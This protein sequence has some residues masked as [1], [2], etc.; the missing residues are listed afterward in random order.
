MPDAKE[1]IKFGSGLRNNPVDYDKNAE[2]IIT[3]EK[4]LGFV[5][6]Q[7]ELILTSLRRIFPYILGKYQI[8]KHQVMIDYMDSS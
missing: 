7:G 2:W 3:V 6:Q 1:S 5:T 4:G 8:R